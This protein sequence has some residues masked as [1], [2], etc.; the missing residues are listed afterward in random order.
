VD[1]HPFRAAWR[2]RE[3]D[4]WI[5]A[6]SQEVVLHSPVVR[7][8]FRGRAAATELYGVLFEIFGEV[9]I[10]GELA[11]ADSHAFFWQAS[12][13]G[14][15]IEGADLLRYDE[16]GKIAEVRVLIRPLVDIATFAAA[17]GPPLAARRSPVRGALVRLLMLPLKG[18]LSIADIVASRL[19]ELH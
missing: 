11:D 17:I 13:G 7:T 15:V 14:R 16:Q 10:T 2:T 9:V 3:L 1:D 8:P 4:T 12:I 5:E 19:I 18:L 6:L